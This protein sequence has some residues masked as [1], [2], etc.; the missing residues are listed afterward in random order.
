METTEQVKPFVPGESPKME[1]A[2]VVIPAPFVP[3]V[4]TAPVVPLEQKQ[5]IVA[6]VPE[7]A[8]VEEV[9]PPPHVFIL[10]EKVTLS[11]TIISVDPKWNRFGVR[12]DGENL[13]TPIDVAVY[14]QQMKEVK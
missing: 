2:P 8:K 6:N 5:A 13:V 14:P 10:G 3:P 4:A 12:L 11:G 7:V 1:P 9:P